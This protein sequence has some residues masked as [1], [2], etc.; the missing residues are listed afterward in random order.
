MFKLEYMA[1]KD[2][3]GIEVEIRV[4]EKVQADWWKLVSRLQLPDVTVDN[5]KA[6]AGWTPYSACHSVF[7]R[8]VSGDGRDPHSWDTVI[9]ALKEIGGYRTFIEEIKHALTAQ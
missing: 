9:K 3:E 8:W 2:D 7:T 6:K 4:V 1:Y 5:E